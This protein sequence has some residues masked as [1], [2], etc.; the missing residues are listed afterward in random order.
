MRP[1]SERLLTYI[2]ELDYHQGG[3]ESL[4][5]EAAELAKRYEEAP[6][7]DLTWSWFS[8]VLGDGSI[9]IEDPEQIRAFGAV[10]SKSRVRIIREPA[11]RDG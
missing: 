1:L 5:A 2:D 11:R 10:E 9:R 6:V 8:P 7:A 4:L 3:G